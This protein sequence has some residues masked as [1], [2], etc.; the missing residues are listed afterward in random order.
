MLNHCRFGRIYAV[1][2]SHERIQDFFRSRAEKSYVDVMCS[3]NSDF[4]RSDYRYC[5]LSNDAVFNG[6]FCV[7]R[8]QIW[9]CAT[10]TLLTTTIVME[11]A[12]NRKGQ[13]PEPYVKGANRKYLHEVIDRIESTLQEDLKGSNVFFKTQT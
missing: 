10:R 13:R 6:W 1:L 11:H 7:T 4:R 8:V 2:L 3:N 5:Q 12:N 9:H